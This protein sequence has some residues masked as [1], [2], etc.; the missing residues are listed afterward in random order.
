MIIVSGTATMKP[1]AFKSLHDAMEKMIAASRA[2]PG[3]I[4]YHYGID[5]LDPDQVVVVEYWESWAALEAHFKTAHMA[6][7]RKALEGNIL[8]FDVKACEVGEMKEI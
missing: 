2:E 6:V 7:W 5:T 4:I 3:C 8:S 1:G